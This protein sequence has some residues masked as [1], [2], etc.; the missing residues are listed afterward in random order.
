LPRDAARTEQRLDL[1]GWIG[2]IH[3]ARSF[4][5]DSRPVPGVG[6]VVRNR[7]SEALNS[8]KPRRF[9]VTAK[10]DDTERVLGV[11]S[12]VRVQLTLS[13]TLA[14]RSSAREPK[15]DRALAPMS[16]TACRNFRVQLFSKERAPTV[17]AA[18]RGSRSKTGRA[19]EGLC[20]EVAG[21]RLA[22]G[23]GWVT[24]FFVSEREPRFPICGSRAMLAA[25]FSGPVPWNVGA[26][27][28]CGPMRFWARRARER[29]CDEKRHTL[30]GELR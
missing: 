8:T 16:R 6:R 25:L 18:S 1:F 22:V 20:I 26:P 23:M 13:D 2:S 28:R 5:S 12:V 15:L 29:H 24:A 14:A 19:R 4:T 10:P 7:T 21:R 3:I 30:G 17:R 27:R 9:A 11:N